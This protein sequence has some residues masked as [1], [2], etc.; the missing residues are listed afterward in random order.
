MSGRQMGG[1]YKPPTL[2]VVPSTLNPPNTSLPCSPRRATRG[3]ERTGANDR[4]D[5]QGGAAGARERPIESTDQ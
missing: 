1:P 5:E 2:G 3:R 4:G